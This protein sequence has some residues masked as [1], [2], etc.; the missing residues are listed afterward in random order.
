MEQHGHACKASLRKKDRKAIH[1]YN[2]MNAP[3]V[4]AEEN[5]KTEQSI[6]IIIFIIEEL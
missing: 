4:C 3:V 2:N 1:T 5:N 6:T